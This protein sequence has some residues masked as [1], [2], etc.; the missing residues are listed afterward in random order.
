MINLQ[1]VDISELLPSNLRTDKAKALGYAVKKALFNICKYADSVRVM[2]MIDDMPEN[3]VNFLAI[4]LR[5]QYYDE[6]LSL[7]VKKSIVK[8]ALERYQKTGTPSIIIDYLESLSGDGMVTIKEWFDYSGDPFHFSVYMTVPDGTVI[9]E[10]FI[11]D[12]EN[13]ISQLKNARS[14]L[15]EVGLLRNG[16]SATN[17]FLGTA[18]VQQTEGSLGESASIIGLAPN[19]LGLV[20]GQDRF[21]TLNGKLLSVE[22][23]E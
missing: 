15:D 16:E 1:S 17:I 23:E 10:A 4:E 12:I 11:A 5:A 22:T 14:I 19:I 9:D 13:K 2:A 6:S 18:S 20:D 7:D 3:I 21:L 8:K